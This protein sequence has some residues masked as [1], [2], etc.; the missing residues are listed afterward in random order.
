M[1]LVRLILSRV[2]SGSAATAGAIIAVVSKSAY[3][4]IRSSCQAPRLCARPKPLEI[5]GAVRPG[6]VSEK[7]HLA[8]RKRERHARGAQGAVEA[9]GQLGSH[10]RKTFEATDPCP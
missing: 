9:L 10:L 4:R 7:T 3:P 5:I 6:L 2:R 1:V 8:L